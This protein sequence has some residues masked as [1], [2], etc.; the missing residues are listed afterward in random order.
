MIFK[1]I[2]SAT[3]LTL[4]VCTYAIAGAGPKAVDNA[5]INWSWPTVVSKMEADMTVL[6]IPSV[7]TPSFLSNEIGLWDAN[8]NYVTE[9]YIGFQHNFQNTGRRSALFSIWDATGATAGTGGICQPFGGEGVGQQCFIPYDWVAG[10][11]Y[12]VRVV[13]DSGVNFSGYVI[14]LS[15]TPPTE[16][17]I[18]QIQAPA[19]NLAKTSGSPVG[20]GGDM[21]QWV[22]WFGSQPGG[23][24]NIPYT[25]VIR[26]QPFGNGGAVQPTSGNQKYTYYDDPLR[27]HNLGSWAASGTDSYMEQGNPGISSAQ[28]LVAAS[29]QFVYASTTAAGCGGGGLRA[30]SNG[31]GDCSQIT[32]VALPDGKVALQAD[33][34]YYLSCTNGGGSTVTAL[35]HIAGIN[36]SFTESTISGKVYY[37]S[38]NGKYL[39]AVNGGGGE[40]RCDGV[41]TGANQG[42]ISLSN[43]ATMASVTVSSESAATSQQGIKAIDGNVGGFPN[44]QQREWATQGESAGAWIQLNWSSPVTV[45]GVTL[46]D[47]PNTGDQVLAG[48]L[49]FSDGTS[50]AVGSL[51]NDAATGL[52]VTFTSRTI[53]WV[54]F[55]I[56]QAAGGNI[57]LAEFQV[58]AGSS[59][60]ASYS[61]GGAVSGLS[62]TG[63]QL[64]NGSD[65][66][67]VSANGSY[68]FPTYLAPGNTYQVTIKTQP[69]GQTCTLSNASGTVTS[70][71]ATNINVV[72]T[73][74]W[75]CLSYTATNSAHVTAQRATKKLNASWKYEYF[76]K[77]SNQSLG[78]VATAS[79][80]LKEDPKGYFAPGQCPAAPT[81]PVINTIT[82]PVVKIVG[83]TA[84]DIQFEVS[85]NGT[86]S[87]INN[88]IDKVKFDIFMGGVDCAGT[89]SF[90]CTYPLSIARTSLPL[91]LDNISQVSATDKTGLTSDVKKIAKLTLPAPSAPV[92][93][94]LSDPSVKKV[95]ED[96]VYVVFDITVTGTASDVDSDLN[97]VNFAIGADQASCSGTGNFTC[98]VRKS[99]AKSSLPLNIDNTGKVTGTDKT[100]LS[101]LAK[102]IPRITLSNVSTSCYTATNSAHRT[103]ARA[104]VKYSS[105][106]YAVGSNTYL[107]GGTT[108]T[109]LQLQSPDYWKKV[110]SCP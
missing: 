20:V 56:D 2:L 45:S 92:I 90:S 27:C 18:G 71:N 94:T 61:I 79:T 55:R 33:D 44:E 54:K 68:A 73:D 84:S 25:K 29:G 1:R 46:Y 65:V 66:I 52:S 49:L 69:S 38:A 58:W 10:K 82:N 9:S 7:G 43:I 35:S 99:A 5:Y 53:S 26:G 37:Q 21:S 59:I 86:A 40:L 14:D 62:G 81:P 75:Q 8:N 63:L 97:S 28:Q 96:A 100:G 93:N 4:G 48:T 74:L 39:T 22:E 105:L 42:F 85:L 108:T 47:R 98:V 11:S 30:D 95:S 60:S 36:E 101:S 107:G 102:V 15:T 3:V 31:A 57:G 34:G 80:T 32:R 64:Q 110:T 103:A 12:R 50:V 88:D 41:S 23:C 6:S 70:S 16:T 76:A 67:N 78:T 13:H 24:A 89:T 19:Q 17:L 104:T 91:I 109:S 87:D 51:P 83:S 77:G 72:C 106:Y